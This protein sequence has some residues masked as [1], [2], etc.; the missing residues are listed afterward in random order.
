MSVRVFP[1]VAD[2]DRDPPENGSGMIGPVFVAA[3]LAKRLLVVSNIVANP[4][5]HSRSPESLL[6]VAVEYSRKFLG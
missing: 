6:Q 1:V 3:F 4:S 2:D 5:V